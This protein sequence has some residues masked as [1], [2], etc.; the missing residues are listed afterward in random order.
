MTTLR[1][2][3]WDHTR[4]LLPLVATAQR[5]HEI[6]GVEI[7]WERRSLQAFADQPIQKLAET[8]DLLIIDHPFAGYAAGHDVLLPLDEH[9]P[10]EFLAEQAQNSV[11]SSFPSYRCGGHQWAMATDA[12]TP[13]ASYRKDLMERHGAALPETWQ[14]LMELARDEMVILPAIPIDSLMSLYYLLVSSGGTIFDGER[15]ADREAAAGALVRL[16]E[17]VD[18]CPRECLE[19]NPI[20]TYDALASSERAFYCPFAYSYSNYGRRGYAPARLH[21][22]GVV[23]IS[24]AVTPRTTLGGTGMAIST[25][26]RDR[27]T[28]LEYL[29]FVHEAETQRTLY[30]DAGGQPG[31]RSAW[32]DEQA[33]DITNDFFR[34]TLATH[35][36]AYL[37][38]R[39]DGYLHFQDAAGPAVHAFLANGGDP[40]A[41]VRSL[42]EVYERSLAGTDALEESSWNLR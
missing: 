42:Q 25:R 29:R 34:D 35:D 39:Y 18:A 30:V 36:D 17:L 26:C 14:E 1:G 20:R 5:F 9:L 2:I 11:G 31:H 22:A 10:S 23:T 37:R 7:N 15:F 28:A 32:L 38:P 13:V 4:G 19:R 21:Y 16:K 8:Y 3:T 41:V 6:H 27:S 24:Q 12:A 33:N 40:R